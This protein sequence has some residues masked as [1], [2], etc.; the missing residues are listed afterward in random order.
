MNHLA[1]KIFTTHAIALILLFSAMLA[2]SA[3]N[4]PPIKLI[5]DGMTID[6]EIFSLFVLPNTLVSVKNLEQESLKIEA[7]SKDFRINTSTRGSFNF[8]APSEPGRYLLEVIDPLFSRQVIL[9]VFVLVPYEK[10]KAGKIE[11]YRIDEYPKK[12]LRGLASYRKPK[13]F[14]RVNKD[15]LNVLVSPHFKLKQ[16]LC[17]QNSGYPKFV[18]LQSKTL[19]MLEDFLSYV[20]DNGFSINTF[21]VISAYRTPYYNK[22]IGNVANSRHVYGDAMDLFIDQNGDGKLDDLDGNHKRNIEDVKI[23]Y[24]L[25]VKFLESANGA[26]T[27]GVGK[28]RPKQHH[29]GFVHIDNRGYSARW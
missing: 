26:Y 19:L 22:S 23:L 27:G 25:A 16:F 13:G 5:V 21:G 4:P 20:N 15:D 6:R 17:K 29:G 7:K 18:V 9:N 24:K 14:V 8:T 11:G 12:P 3:S 10:M 1:F 28:Y 2:N